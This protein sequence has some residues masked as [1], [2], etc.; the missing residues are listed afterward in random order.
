ME[1]TLSKMIKAVLF[2]MDGVLYD[3]M[4]NHERSWMAAFEA[5]GVP[6]EAS[7]AYLNEGRTGRSTVQTTIRK[8]FGREATEAEIEGIYAKKSEII[9]TCPAAPMIREMHD[10]VVRLRN[11][12]I[13]T[14]VVTGSKQPQLMSRLWT[15]Y[16]FRRDEI[17]NGED[18]R[19]GKP[20][21][22]PYL[23]AI[24]R[25]GLR[26]D[27]CVVVENAPLGIRS[28]KAAG[29]YCI[30]VNTG[31]LSDQVLLEAGADRIASLDDLS[32]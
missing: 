4:P 2:D 16:G 23:I 11:E 25:A 19:H 18:V 32:I 28:A 22:E 24:E 5:Y 15:D 8:A 29:C 26:A 31:K 1:Q 3:S 6:F 30:A 17:V 7:D 27:E 10:F 12:G 20:D 13:K 9:K 14:L 21:P